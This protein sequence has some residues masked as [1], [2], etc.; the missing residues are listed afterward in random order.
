MKLVVL[1]LLAALWLVPAVRLPAREDAN[2]QA[3]ARFLAKRSEILRA[4]RSLAD[5]RRSLE[6]TRDSSEKNSDRAIADINA[7][8]AR[9]RGSR[10][11]R[12]ASGSGGAE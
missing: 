4:I 6:K 12:A 9:L 8:I 7:A 5:A 11:L 1:P 3:S 2:P 10:Y